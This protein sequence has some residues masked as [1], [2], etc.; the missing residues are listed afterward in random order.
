MSNTT[1][2]YHVVFCTR[3]R[4]KTI[5][6]DHREDLYRYI[7]RCI[8]DH[9]CKLLRIGGVAD[10]VHMLIDLHPTVGLSDL[11][12]AV[13]ANSSGWLRSDPRFDG[14]DGWGK[15]YFAS[16]IAPK[17]KSGVIE[18]IKNQEVHHRARQFDDELSSLH[19]EAGMELD[20]RDFR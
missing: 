17:D 3:H 18:Y 4:Q 15:E 16:T 20:D 9:K 8:T 19:R 13:K 6:L 10:H 1:A 2:L 5:P 7:W 12:R 14:F 11:M